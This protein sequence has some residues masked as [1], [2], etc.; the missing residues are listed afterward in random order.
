MNPFAKELFAL[1]PFIKKTHLEFVDRHGNRLDYRMQLKD[2]EEV[3]V[4]G[5]MSAMA[6]LSFDRCIRS[7]GIPTWQ[8]K[9][10]RKWRPPKT[11]VLNS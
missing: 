2:L 6:H 11:N 9:A 10:K 4:T 1:Q 8:S 7:K 5:A 3:S